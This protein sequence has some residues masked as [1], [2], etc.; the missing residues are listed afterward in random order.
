M[1]SSIAKSH[2]RLLFFELR[3]PMEPLT[4]ST[5]SASDAHETALHEPAPADRRVVASTSTAHHTDAL[6]R[7]RTSAPRSEGDEGAGTLVRRR[8]ALPLGAEPESSS[9]VVTTRPVTITQRLQRLASESGREHISEAH[10]AIAQTAA[11]VLYGEHAGKMPVDVL[12]SLLERAPLF[13]KHGVTTKAEMKGFL[14]RSFAEWVSPFIGRMGYLMLPFYAQHLGATVP[15]PFTGLAIGAATMG[16]TIHTMAMQG[17]IE[18]KHIV[19]LDMT[20]LPQSVRERHEAYVKNLLPAGMSAELKRQAVR[21]LV[22]VAPAAVKAISHESM[23][24]TDVTT[25]DVYA[26]AATFFGAELIDDIG[27]LVGA[28]KNMASSAEQSKGALARQGVQAPSHGEL[29]AHQPLDVL[30]EKLVRH[31]KGW[32]ESGIG[33]T[34]AAGEGLA[35]LWKNQTLRIPGIALHAGCIIFS[36][37]NMTSGIIASDPENKNLPEGQI[38]PRSALAVPFALMLTEYFAT[39]AFDT[40]MRTCDSLMN[41]LGSIGKKQPNAQFATIEDVETGDGN[42]ESVEE[43]TTMR[44]T[45]HDSQAPAVAQTEGGDSRATESATTAAPRNRNRQPGESMTRRGAV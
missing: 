29:I 7:A 37:L 32:V 42:H 35:N 34:K 22:T 44:R 28:L 10:V 16:T 26:D 43:M 38:T 11:E 4:I 12:E 27:Q 20:G 39:E 6:P 45:S 24:H 40:L 30:E 14:Q 41:T 19:P 17:G 21:A 2:F 33:A 9:A 23:N 3:I 25:N 36:A 18:R 5:E 8:A 1:M 15:A 31:E 13:E